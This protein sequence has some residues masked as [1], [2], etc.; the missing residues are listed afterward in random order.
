[1]EIEA[2]ADFVPLFQT[3][4]W[5]ALAT[6]ILVYFRTTIVDIASALRERIL[7]GTEVETPW[8]TLREAPKE[9]RGESQAVA[10]SEGAGGSAVP[11]DVQEMLKEQRYPDVVKTDVY[12]IHAAETVRPRRPTRPGLWRVRVWVEAYTPGALSGIR[13]VSY[14]LYQDDF[15]RPVISTEDRDR[16]FELWISVY[17]EF[18]V[19]AYA[20]LV[21]GSGLWLTRYLDLPGRPPE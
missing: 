16:D 13:R 15:P 21:G 12:L 11:S 1:M 9:I 18:T 20:E 4:A 14:R 2:M 3:L 17:G 19:V 6:V 10:T 7:A 8:L 5:V